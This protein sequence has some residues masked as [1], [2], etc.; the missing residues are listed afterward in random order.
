MREA[1]FEAKV[2]REGEVQGPRLGT[3]AVSCLVA[4]CSVLVALVALVWGSIQLGGVAAVGF[5]VAILVALGSQLGLIGLMFDLVRGTGGEP[6]TAAFGPE[7]IE[8]RHASEAKRYG[9]DQVRAISVTIT[10][11]ETGELVKEP[12][13]H[14]E[15]GGG[16]R[17]GLF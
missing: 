6:N 12:R 7:G 3:L 8:R 5:V 2:L 17:R 16:L 11:A 15:V 4:L 1:S 13:V 14:V 9:W 10:E